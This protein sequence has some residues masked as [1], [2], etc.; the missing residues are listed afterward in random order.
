MALAGSGW[1]TGV[2]LLVGDDVATFPVGWL[3]TTGFDDR[4]YFILFTTR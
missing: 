3:L 1:I 4:H 2:A